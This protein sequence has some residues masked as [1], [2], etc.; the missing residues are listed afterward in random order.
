MTRNSN[1]LCAAADAPSITW[2][3][4]WLMPLGDDA[5]CGQDLEYDTEFVVLSARLAAKPDVQYGDFVGL[6]APVNWSDVER[7][8]RRL[9]TRSKDIRLA[10]LF[11]RCRTR[12]AGA[13][14]VAQGLELLAGWLTAFPAAIH[15]QLAVDP[16]VDAARAI[17]M[18]ALRALADAQG[19]LGD[20]RD[21][22]LTRTRSTQLQVRDVERAFAQP[23][24]DDAMA[25]HQ[26]EQQLYELY[27]A[28]AAL[29]TDF[30]RALA[31]LEQTDAWSREY[32]GTM[33]IP[34]LGPLVDVLRYLTNVPV[35]QPAHAVTSA[36]ASDIAHAAA[37]GQSA[38]HQTPVAA[39]TEPAT[40]APPPLPLAS[41]PIEDRRAALNQIRAVR[42]W[43]ELH[44]PSS[45][46]PVLLRRAE[47]FFGKPYADTIHAVPA[48]LLA[49]WSAEET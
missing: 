43:F 30:G 19:L 1:S 22:V 7:D 6:P 23:H 15:P 49:N 12:L 38:A 14:G 33:F 31:A 47:Q 3:S 32:L 27:A 34:E 48:E 20:V 5:P 11:A 37:W 25:S 13:A 35:A 41:P 24:A 18:N 16:D 46:I 2:P 17:R 10:V 21:I 40:A 44:E 8:C 29:R 36:G 4:E 26:V 42:T 9:M 39:C 45:P 28:Q